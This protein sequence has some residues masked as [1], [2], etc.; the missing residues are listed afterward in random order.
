[1]Q[2]GQLNACLLALIASL[3]ASSAFGQSSKPPTTVISGNGDVA[4]WSLHPNE[5]LE[6]TTT[7]TVPPEPER[8]GTLFL[9]PGL[10]P[11]SEGGHFLPIDNG[12]LQPVLTWGPSC[13]K[14]VQPVL[15]SSWWISA[16]Y[17]NTFGRE[18]GYKGCKGGQIL[19]V[20]PGDMLRIKMSLAGTKWTQTIDNLQSGKSTDYTIDMRSQAQ[21]YILFAVE[22]GREGSPSVADVVFTDTT[23]AFLNADLRNCD[24][25]RRGENDVVTPPRALNGGKTCYIDKIT[26]RSVA[27]PTIADPSCAREGSIKSAVGQERAEIGFVNTR[28]TAARLYWIDGNGARVPYGTIESGKTLT[29][30]TFIGHAWVIADLLDRCIGLYLPSKHANV[31]IVR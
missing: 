6:L 9:W 8:F 20:N 3:T 22:T 19:L 12:V 15:Y 21:N 25:Q 29:Q 1:M 28:S 7:L 26:L 11:G 18:S 14:G 30:Q 27:H 4:F 10:Q 31:H 24:L 17:V 16:Q 13:A 23:I 5:V 2:A